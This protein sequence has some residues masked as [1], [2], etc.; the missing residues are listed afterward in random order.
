[1]L[2][3]ETKGTGARVVPLESVLRD[4]DADDRPG[5]QI[6]R[7][8]PRPRPEPPPAPKAPRRFRVI[9]VMTR[10]VLG[11]GD[12]RATVELLEPLRSIVDV[13]IYVWQPEAGEWRL[14]THAEKQRLWEARG[15]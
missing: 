5:P 11:E 3:T 10:L 7:A 6:V 4:P 12:A 8:K 13:S 15:G 1:M 14:L 9:D 2:E